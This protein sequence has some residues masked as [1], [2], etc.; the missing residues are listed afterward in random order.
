MTYMIDKTAV[1]DEGAI[2]GEGTKVWHFCH[3]MSGARIGKNCTLGQNVFIQDGVVIG[4]NCKIQNNVSIYKG[5]ILGD[6]V[7]VGPSAVFTNVKKPKSAQPVSP[8]NYAQTI[9]C[10]GVSIGAN[11][12]I[13]CGVIIG[14]NATIG[15]GAVVT[16]NIP[17]GITVIGNPAG[18]LVSDVKGTPFVVSFSEYH[19]KR[20]NNQR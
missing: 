13:V 11:A 20:I 8:D 5:V 14:E 4:D 3:I 12:T 6:N 7:F 17:P 1:V 19:I 16:K 15:A 18:I 10:D 9:V 2:I